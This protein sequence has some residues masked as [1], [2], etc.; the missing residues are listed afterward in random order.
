MLIPLNLGRLAKFT[1]SHCDRITAQETVI[2]RLF[3]NYMTPRF[4]DPSLDVG[5]DA[6]LTYAFFAQLV[7]S[8]VLRPDLFKVKRLCVD[9]DTTPGIAY[10][11][12]YGYNRGED[13]EGFSHWPL[14]TGAR[15]IAV[16]SEVDFEATAE[17]VIQAFTRSTE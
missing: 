9:V 5:E 10:G 13:D 11:A 6:R 7:T 12:T 14:E 3:R 8:Y 16:A 17:M 15:P 2:G 1:R 4:E